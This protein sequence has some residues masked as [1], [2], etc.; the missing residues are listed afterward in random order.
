MIELDILAKSAGNDY[1]ISYGVVYYK[2][3]SP[4]YVEILQIVNDL[5]ETR[6]IYNPI[7]GLPC[8]QFDKKNNQLWLVIGQPKL[9]S[10]FRMVPDFENSERFIV[11]NDPETAKY[12]RLDD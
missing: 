8:Y 7:S 6:S 2:H 9:T 11:V 3:L 10:E 1:V 4:M 5:R 12:I